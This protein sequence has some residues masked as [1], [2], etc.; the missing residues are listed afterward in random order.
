M[1]EK[2]EKWEGAKILLENFVRGGGRAL[3]YLVKTNVLLWD[4]IFLI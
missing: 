3:S 4:A 1:G 2:G